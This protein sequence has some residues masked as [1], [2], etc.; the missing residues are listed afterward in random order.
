[1]DEH[2]ESLS[3]NILYADSERK[4]QEKRLELASCTDPEKTVELVTQIMALENFKRSL[5][6]K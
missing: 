3:L 5:R 2:L 6:N 1:L 4:V